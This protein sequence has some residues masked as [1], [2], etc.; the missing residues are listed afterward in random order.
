MSTQD[1]RDD[2]ANRGNWI[3]PSSIAFVA[4]IPW[5]EDASIEN[6]IVFG[7]P[8]DSERYSKVPSACA[9]EKDIEML[10]DRE[11]IEIGASGINLSG[12]QRWRITVARALYSRVGVLIFDDIFSA[13][14]AHV[15]HHIIE[16]GLA[17]EPRELT[18]GRTQILVTHY[19]GLVQPIARYVVH[20]GDNGYIRSAETMDSTQA[21]YTDAGVSSSS[22]SSNIS[23][24]M[25]H[26]PPIGNGTPKQA[27]KKFIEGEKR[28]NG[29]ISTTIF[30]NYM[31]SSGGI[32]YWALVLGVFMLVPLLYLADHGG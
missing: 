27:A 7:L 9:L 32:P 17:G 23:D 2:E 11:T 18:A 10:P 8:L 26:I 1:R 25:D 15:G 14:D 30:K 13:V 20:L 3:L 6:N 12:G 21:R 28:E 4:Q 31:D 29:R 24:K 5:L 16:H 19:I 22:S